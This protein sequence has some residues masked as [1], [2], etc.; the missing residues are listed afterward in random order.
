MRAPL[1]VSASR[2]RLHATSST[3]LYE[4]GQ[5]TERIAGM[6]QTHAMLLQTRR[7]RKPVRNDMVPA[8]RIHALKHLCR[9]EQRGP[10]SSNLGPF[11]RLLYPFSETLRC[12]PPG[13]AVCLM[14]AK[15]CSIEANDFC[16]SSQ[17]VEP[18]RNHEVCND[19]DLRGEPR[20]AK[21]SQALSST[22]VG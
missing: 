5:G 20:P 8:K 14:A 17:L 9:T 2:P 4:P 1:S 3:T 21:A 12:V 11:S 19:D 7:S 6:R 18:I 10:D 15:A 22:G 16:F 13:L